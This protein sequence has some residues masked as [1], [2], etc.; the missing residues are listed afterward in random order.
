MKKKL[1]S[2]LTLFLVMVFFSSGIAVVFAQDETAEFTLEEITV[3]AAKTGEEDLQK[4]PIAMEVI[5]GKDFASAAKANVDDILEGLS[6]VFINTSADGMRIS[7][8]GIA[9][10]DPVYGG[11]KFSSPTVAMNVDGAYNAMNTSGQNLFDVERIEVLMGPQ[12][13]LYS[14]NSPGGVVNIVTAAPK[15]DKFSGNFSAEYGSYERSV[16]QAALNVP[17][18]M[19]KV[20]VRLSLNR[21][22]ENSFLDTDELATKNDAARLKLLWSATDDFEMTLIGNYAKNGNRGE[23]GDSVVQFI[24]SSNDAWTAAPNAG[25][26]GGSS[27]GNDLDQ[28]TKGGSANISWNTPVGNLTVV[29]SYSESDSSGSQTG[30]IILGP[31]GPPGTPGQIIEQGSWE[32]K[33]VQTQ[34]G[35]E[36]RMASSE[37]F[38]FKYVM[39]ATYYKNEFDAAQTYEPA[40]SSNDSWNDMDSTQKAVYANIT[41]PLPFNEKLSLVA[42]YRYSWDDAHQ[43]SFQ[44]GRGNDE[45]EMNVSNPDVKVGF[46]YDSSDSMMFYGNY[47]SSFRT[48]SQ[49]MSN[50]VGVRPAEELTAYTLGAKTR[51]FNNRVQ[52]NTSAFYYDYLNKFAQDSPS[53]GNFTQADL[54]SHFLPGGTSYYDYI[55]AQGGGRSNVVDGVTYYAVDDGGFNGWGDA[56]SFGLDL[57]VSWIATE[58]DKVEFTASYLD[59]EWTS[60]DFIYLYTDFFPNHNYDGRTGPN[61]PKLSMT[62]NYEHRFDIGSYGT[63]VPHVEMQYRSKFDLIFDQ[64]NDPGYGR[65][66]AYSIFNASVAFNSA[67]QKWSVNGIVKNITDYAVKRSYD[68]E[69]Q[70]LRIGDPRTY[71]ITASVN[72]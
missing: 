10:T 56:R 17:I 51:L 46:Q 43:I 32:S 25:G 54:E 9:D 50:N 22:R 7:I 41:Y 47:S 37:D 20:A 40:Y 35:A 30:S 61:A 1:V 39:G 3:T 24:T 49:A 12:S 70:T 69:Q 44:P 16:L 34:K 68:K 23:M 55:M 14:S 4:V 8:R 36:A 21:T 31:P 26:P 64:S 33:R 59:M 5:T 19:D 42:G 13:T 45:T 72:F 27:G 28:I 67:S 58:K 38:S 60:L 62:A 11:Q 63:L 65:Q 53:R 52:V 71:S 18:I 6:N 57:S 66:E 2:F 15:T 29:P 48:D